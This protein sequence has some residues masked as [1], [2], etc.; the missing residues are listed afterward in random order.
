[1]PKK[2][3]HNGTPKHK[4]SKSRVDGKPTKPSSKLSSKA[5]TPQKPTKPKSD[6]KKP[7]PPKPK[8]RVCNKLVKLFFLNYYIMN[9]SRHKRTGIFCTL[10]MLYIICESPS[11]H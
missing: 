8:P 10:E 4:E 3:S 11:G 1:M 7:S 6:S 5:E 9:H 2:L